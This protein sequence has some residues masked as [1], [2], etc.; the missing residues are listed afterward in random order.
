MNL[1]DKLN[2]S[3][4]I[5]SRAINKFND[6]CAVSCS[7]G[8]DSL[9]VLK[10]ALEIK[11]DIKVLFCNTLNEF[12]ETIELMRRL[13]DEWNL[14]LIETRPYKNMTFRKCLDKYGLPKIRLKGSNSHSPRCCWYLKEKPAIEAIKEYNIKCLLTG[15]TEAESY[16][17]FLLSKRYEKCSMEKDGLHYTSFY[18]FAK[19]WNVWKFHPIMK[20]KEKEVFDLTTKLNIPLNEV[21]TKWDCIYRRCGCLMCTAYLDWEKKLSITHPNIYKFLLKYKEID[22]EN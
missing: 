14:N 13:K 4:R 5:I 6:D 2:F 16:N 8:K 15:L 18:Y 12:P 1:N 20:L 10:K 17:R 11:P 21:Y 19:T 9:L 7:F 3:I 22:N